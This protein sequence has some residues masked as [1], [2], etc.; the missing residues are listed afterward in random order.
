MFPQFDF[1]SLS[2]TPAATWGHSFRADSFLPLGCP[3]CSQG[4]PSAF[5]GSPLRWR[6]KVLGDAPSLALGCRAGCVPPRPLPSAAASELRPGGGTTGMSGRTRSGGA[7]AGRGR[8]AATRATQT[9]RR[10]AR[11]LPARPRPQ[12]W[13]ACSSRPRRAGLGRQ[14]PDPGSS[15]DRE[16]EREVSPRAPA[17]AGPPRPPSPDSRPVTA[18]G[19]GAGRGR[20][21]WGGPGWG[22]GGGP[23][24]R[25]S[26]PPRRPG[27]PRPQQRRL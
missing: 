5:G 23:G 27:S 13:H 8:D 26:A 2:I 11:R 24:A 10:P 4:V 9:V 18:R 15:A 7:H 6:A 17:S 19:S 1:G 20:R 3:T 12:P 21:R 14:P 16:T 22:R 25:V